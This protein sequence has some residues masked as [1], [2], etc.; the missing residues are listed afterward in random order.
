MYSGAPLETNNSVPIKNCLLL[1][2]SLNTFRRSVLGLGIFSNYALV[3][4]MKN[5]KKFVA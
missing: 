5:S 3:L 2:D 4:H 1:W